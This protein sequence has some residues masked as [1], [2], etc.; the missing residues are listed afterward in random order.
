MNRTEEY[1]I[2]L[3]IRSGSK[4]ATKLKNIKHQTRLICLEAVKKILII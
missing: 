2:I 1:N 4:E 3:D